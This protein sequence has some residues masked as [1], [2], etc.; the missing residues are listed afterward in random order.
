MIRKSDARLADIPNLPPS[1]HVMTTDTQVHIRPPSPP[2]RDP[3]AQDKFHPVCQAPVEL[4]QAT[5]EAFDKAQA[6][7]SQ[8]I[9]E[10]AVPK[11]PGSDVTVLPL[12]TS[13]AV[14]SKYRNGEIVNVGWRDE[15]VLTC[16]ISFLDL[17][18]YTGPWEHSPGLRRGYVGAAS[19]GI[20]DG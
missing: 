18:S 6:V 20:R 3:Y 13:S 17:D 5:R 4:T 15:M 12:G 19:E 9:A 11:L 2:K 7:V 16:A 1:T 14:P 10:G 8:R